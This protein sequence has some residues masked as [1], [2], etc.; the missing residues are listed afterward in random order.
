MT[1]G[2]KLKSIRS[3]L[4]ISQAHH[5]IDEN[6]AAFV[7][8]MEWKQRVTDA[9]HAGVE[10]QEEIMPYEIFGEDDTDHAFTYHKHR[11]NWLWINDVKPWAEQE[12]LA[13]IIC[14]NRV[15]D[16]PEIHEFTIR[17]EPTSN[18]C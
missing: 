11:H 6:A 2:D 15:S 8:F 14:S 18:N 12:G 3:K 10:P 1:L 17:V 5:E 4:K 16:F 7:W 9:I 13:V